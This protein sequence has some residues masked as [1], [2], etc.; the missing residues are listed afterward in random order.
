MRGS[1]SCWLSSQLAF[2][3]TWWGGR[4]VQARAA[5]CHSAPG[6]QADAPSPQACPHGHRGPLVGAGPSLPFSGSHFLVVTPLPFCR[7]WFCKS[8]NLGTEISP[9]A[10]WGGG[11]PGNNGLAPALLPRPQTTFPAPEKEELGAQPWGGVL[12]QEGRLQSCTGLSALS[13][14]QC[15]APPILIWKSAH[16]SQTA[17]WII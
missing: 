13:G 10:V 1:C 6:S 14:A 17:G 3:R 11:G 15:S 12:F 16:S 9:Q 5:A 7:L 2:R 8:R 4:P